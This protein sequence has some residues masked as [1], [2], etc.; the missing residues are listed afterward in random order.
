LDLA[1]F[2][3]RRNCATRRTRNIFCHNVYFE[4]S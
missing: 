3:L 4:L 2:L 1:C